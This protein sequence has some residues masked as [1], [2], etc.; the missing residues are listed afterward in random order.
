MDSREQQ[1]LEKF[2][3]EQ[4]RK[5]PDNPAPADI[6]GN[7]LARIEARKNLPW[8]KRSFVDWPRTIQSVFIVTLS[9]L[10][11]LLVYIAAIPAEQF[12]LSA[13]VTRIQ[14]L[15]WVGELFNALAGSLLLIVKNMSWQWALA[16]GGVFIVMYST[17]VAGGMVLYRVTTQSK[18]HRN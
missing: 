3:H 5:L 14:S 18:P 1:D 15:S 16:V 12:S 17:C 13:L 2:I 11:G 8:W 9:V 7:V 4:L 6:V 10:L